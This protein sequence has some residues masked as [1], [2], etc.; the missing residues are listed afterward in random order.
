MDNDLLKQKQIALTCLS[1]FLILPPSL[2][3]PGTPLLCLFPLKLKLSQESITSPFVSG[4]T[5]GSPR[6]K[7]QS[8]VLCATSLF[9]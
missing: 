4:N 8:H 9:T 5:T 7:V 1:L 3:S 6:C 2:F